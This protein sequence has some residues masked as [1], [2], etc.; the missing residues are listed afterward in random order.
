MDT[1]HVDQPEQ[2]EQQKAPSSICDLFDMYTKN[3]DGRL[4]FLYQIR[5]KRERRARSIKFSV[6]AQLIES[7][8][9]HLNLHSVSLKCLVSSS[10][11]LRDEYARYIQ[12]ESITSQKPAKAE[13]VNLGAQCFEIHP[14]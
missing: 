14:N 4:T 7:V 8:Y 6:T 9:C 13:Q 2:L 11:S 5:P 3:G 12:V 10:P 1:L